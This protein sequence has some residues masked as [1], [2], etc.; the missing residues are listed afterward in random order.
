MQTVPAVIETTTSYPWP[1]IVLTTAGG[2][3]ESVVSRNPSDRPG[4]SS[5]TSGRPGSDKPNDNG[6]PLLTPPTA[7]G[8][9][10]PV[11]RGV[12]GVTPSIGQVEQRYGCLTM[13]SVGK[14]ETLNFYLFVYSVN[15]F[16]TF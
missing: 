10:Y 3:D 6:E 8:T 2:D 1:T 12:A 7:P 11:R 16:V 13:K 15:Y 4:S 9:I 14:L 5:T